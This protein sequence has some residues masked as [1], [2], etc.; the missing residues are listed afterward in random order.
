V[1][2]TKNDTLYTR[3]QVELSIIAGW[4]PKHRVLEAAEMGDL[5]ERD[6]VARFT[7]AWRVAK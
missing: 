5:A 4:T 1:R 7:F 6:A 3:A 2:I